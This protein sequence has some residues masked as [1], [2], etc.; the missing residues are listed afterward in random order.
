MNKK[1]REAFD[2]IQAEEALKDRTKAYI[3]WK[4]QGYT[5]RKTMNYRYLISAAACVIFLLIGGYRIYF[6]PTAEISIDINPSIELGV[7]RFDR[8]VS[9]TGRN[10]DGQEIADSLHIRYVDYAE[11]V[12]RIMENEEIEALLSNGEILTVVVVGTD[13]A[14]SS[15]IL[16]GVQ[17]CTA[18]E[19]NAYCYRA[20]SSEVEK[21]HE[22]GLSYGKYKAYLEL[23]KLDP[24]I[25]AEQ[26]KN[27]TM[28]EIR[29]LISQLSEGE[30]D[31]IDHSGNGKGYGSGQGN[32]N[33][34][35]QGQ[36]K[37]RR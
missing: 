26:I 9:V 22:L 13:E 37:G 25:D 2:Q 28:R 36:R 11:A 30:E 18:E 16:S 4:T 8:I 17:S 34:N 31:E 19:K 21:A 32:G 10:S 14:Q 1:I 29:E 12:D 15:Q 3:S 6:H 24:N 20:D 35:G 5:R 33:G 27:M 7:N 23:K